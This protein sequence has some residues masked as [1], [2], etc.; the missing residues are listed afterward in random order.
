[1]KSPLAKLL[2]IAPNI[3]N[4]QNTQAFIQQAPQTNYGNFAQDMGQ[5]A[6]QQQAN[7]QALTNT[8]NELKIQNPQEQ[9]VVAQPNDINGVKNN[10]LSGFQNFQRGFNENVNS[11]FSPENFGQNQFTV[12]T[13]ADTAKLQAYQQQL[14]DSGM[15]GNEKINNWDKLTPE[16]KQTIVNAVAEGKNSG[17]APIDNWIKANPDAL[18]G[19]T[20]VYEKTPMGRF[21]E[22]AG[23]AVKFANTPLGQ[24]LIQGGIAALA[25]NDWRAGLQAGVQAA[26]D[27][28]TSNMYQNALKAE[29]IDTGN[30]GFFGNLS[31]KDY[32]SFMGRA[33][34]KWD[35][36]FKLSE[37]ARNQK[38]ADREFERKIKADENTANYRNE[39]LKL[40]KV[41]AANKGKGG[42]GKGGLTTAQQLKLQKE[43]EKEAKEQAMWDAA[44]KYKERIETPI[45]K[46]FWGKPI[47]MSPEEQE[48][49]KWAF[50]Q[51]FHKNPDELIY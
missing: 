41:K 44:G 36:D 12:T 13:P 35:R 16:A 1:M 6:I 49:M 24:A 25:N 21:G 10:L 50:K 51:Q 22:F 11:S 43:K 37:S 40:D 7:N 3:L 31:S 26:Q 47:Y 32:N 46:N 30:A 39:K 48:K 9:P 28:A 17:Y 29:G 45:G 34:K 23:T 8:M 18:N 2:E 33:D 4:K 42:G 27:R 14:L 15:S 20:Q 19:T 5:Q 38:N